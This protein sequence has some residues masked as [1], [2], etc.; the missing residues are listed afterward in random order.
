MSARVLL[1]ATLSISLLAGC[2]KVAPTPT[3]PL[4]TQQTANYRTARIRLD[5]PSHRELRLLLADTDAERELG[6]GQRDRLPE[7][8]MLFVIDP[9]APTSIWMKGM[10]F[11]LDILWLKQGRVV[12]VEQAVPLATPTD[13]TPPTYGPTQAVDAVLEIA[14][15]QAEELGLGVGSTVTLLGLER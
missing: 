5:A 9:A 12:Q 6:L 14:S 10:Q 15:G 2:A 13:P 11:S 3:W 7:E 1:A 4:T 8:G